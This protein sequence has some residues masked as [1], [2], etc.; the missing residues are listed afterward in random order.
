LKQPAL[1]VEFKN[2]LKNPWAEE[3]IDLLFFRP[4]AFLFVQFLR[5]LPVT[6]N[7]V[8]FFAMLAGIAGGYYLSCGSRHHFLIGGIFYGL[9]NILDC[10]DG[11]IARLKKNGTMTGRIVDGC[12]DYVIAI[13]V[14]CGLAMGLSKAVLSGELHLPGGAWLLTV[15]AAASFAAHA[16]FSDKYRNAFL[17]SKKKAD[18]HPENEFEKFSNELNRLQ[19]RKGQLF[20]KVLIRIYLRYMLLQSGGKQPEQNVSSSTPVTPTSTKT[21]VLWNLIG[22]STHVAAL[23]VS[24]LLYN[25]TFFFIFVIGIANL[26]MLALLAFNRPKT[27][28]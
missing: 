13:A 7:Q 15:L 9:A 3:A 12:I 23:V 22:P 11:M 26:W 16:V 5:L 8:S 4:V 19:G 17:L 10:C 27:K 20:D 28:N 18:N 21:V 1:F 2:S 24:A 6:P 14:Y 25:P